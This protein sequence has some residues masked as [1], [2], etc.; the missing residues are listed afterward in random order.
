MH[1]FLCTHFS[2]FDAKQIQ[3]VKVFESHVSLN[4]LFVFQFHR[5]MLNGFLSYN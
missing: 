4:N 1:L 3:Q 5:N 2:Q